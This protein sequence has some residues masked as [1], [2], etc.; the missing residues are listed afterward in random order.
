METVVNEVGAFSRVYRNEK[1]EGSKIY[2]SYFEICKENDFKRERPNKEK[3]ACNKIESIIWEGGDMWP[4]GGHS[5]AVGTQT[6]HAITMNK[7]NNRNILDD[8]HMVMNAMAKNSDSTDVFIGSAEKEQKAIAKAHTVNMMDSL[9]SVNTWVGPVTKNSLY[10]IGS[11]MAQ[12]HEIEKIVLL[13]SGSWTGAASKFDYD[14][15][16]KAAAMMLTRRYKNIYLMAMV[17]KYPGFKVIYLHD[18]E[19]R[20]VE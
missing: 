2:K 3:S 12:K 9:A 17:Y 14:T 5:S 4:K 11:K 19:M 18:G 6:I 15:N 20:E 16:F 1:Y 13:T 7:Y 10:Y 8:N